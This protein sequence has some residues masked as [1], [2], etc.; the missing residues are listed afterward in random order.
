MSR[1]PGYAASHLPRQAQY[2]VNAAEPT[3]FL[4]SLMAQALRH[5]LPARRRGGQI[6]SWVGR[7][8]LPT[9]AVAGLLRA[10]PRQEAPDLDALL[11]DLKA[12]W[13]RLANESGRLPATPPSMSALALN[14]SAGRTVFVFGSQLHPLVVVKQPS[15][16]RQGVATEAAALRAAEPAA[17]APA[18]LGW[19]GGAS[20]QEG[21]PGQPAPVVPVDPTR[22]GLLPW[23]ADFEQ[24]QDALSRLAAET[25][26]RA[27]LTERLL[28]PLDVALAS[29]VIGPRERE[30]L[31]A[32]RRDLGALDVAVLQHG[33]ASAQNWLVAEGRFQAL[34]DWELATSSGIP[35]FDILN[36]AVSHV[37]HGVGLLRWSED[38]VIEAFRR[39]WSDSPLFARARNAAREAAMATGVPGRLVEQL[40]VAFF[41]RRLGRRLTAPQRY[42]VGPQGASAILAAA[43]ES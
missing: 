30:L 41:G 18:L 26:Q 23:T 12:A 1:R 9:K 25:A 40:E 28:A 20:V 10:L 7:R 39:A 5:G 22:A 13:P 2:S 19:L 4:A 35:G 36:A 6:A 37:E 11:D 21:L 43:C 31:K 8:G 3:A 27:D 34:V 17:I 38:R 42:P 16:G 32:A 29:D 14:R 24:L 33:D 15:M